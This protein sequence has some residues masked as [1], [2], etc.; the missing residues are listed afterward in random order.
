MADPITRMM[1]AV[2]S[3]SST[4]PKFKWAEDA[5]RDIIAWANPSLN[6]ATSVTKNFPFAST[7][8]IP[9][10]SFRRPSFVCLFPSVCVCV[11]VCLCVCV[12]VYV[13][14]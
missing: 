6:Q 14:G 9:N 1:A 13:S 10:M 5:G 4:L 11:S 8:L 3:I 12:S 7:V 2:G